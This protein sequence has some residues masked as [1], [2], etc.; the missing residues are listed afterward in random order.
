M[1]TTTFSDE[2]QWA[3]FTDSS[4][5][6]PIIKFRLR[7]SSQLEPFRYDA[8]SRKGASGTRYAMVLVR[9][10]DDD[11][12]EGDHA[13]EIL[14]PAGEGKAWVAQPD[15]TFAA[16]ETAPDAPERPTAKPVFPRGLTGLAIDWARLS[17]FWQWLGDE[18]GATVETEKQARD[19]ICYIC[20]CASRR[21]LNTDQ[22]AAARFVELIK[23]P[24]AESRKARGLD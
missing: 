1:V 23:Q 5:A 8:V 19:A 3:G 24:Y 12:L 6:G 10:M 20:E 9:L 2:V 17:D 7:D 16:V 13:I 18:F 14:P 11:T 22:Q 21:D 4:T 15:G